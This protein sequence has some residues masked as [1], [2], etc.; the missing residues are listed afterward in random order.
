MEET[1]SACAFSLQYPQFTH[2]DGVMEKITADLCQN[3]TEGAKISSMQP[4]ALNLWQ[5][6]LL[7]FQATIHIFHF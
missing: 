3:Q 4:L 1:G 5:Q 6:C 2:N 7:A